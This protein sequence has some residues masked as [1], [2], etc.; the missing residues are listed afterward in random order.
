[1]LLK[2]GSV[3][4]DRYE[5][6]EHLG[7]GGMG[8]CFKAIDLTLDRVIVLKTL[9]VTTSSKKALIRFQ[10]EAKALSN[11]KH[12]GLARLYDFGVTNDGQPFLVLE[13]V[14]GISLTELIQTKSRLELHQLLR[15][16]IQLARALEY[17]HNEGIVHRDIKPG[18]IVLRSEKYAPV[19]I[20][21]GIAKRLSDSVENALRVT[22][23]GQA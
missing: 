21:F 1:M 16:F 13:F 4:H 20:D 8:L 2:P 17:A 10:L 6:I 18:N 9:P 22:E 5:I 12:E 3:F 7:K 23:A 19:L 14:D 15:M 11:L